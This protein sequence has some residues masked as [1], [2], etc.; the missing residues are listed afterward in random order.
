MPGFTLT[1][2]MAERNGKIEILILRSF[3]LSG[4][5]SCFSGLLFGVLVLTGKWHQQGICND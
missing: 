1:N 3:V 5:W 2:E 4:S